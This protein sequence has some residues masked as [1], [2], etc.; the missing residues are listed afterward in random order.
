MVGRI[1]GTTSCRSR[2]LGEDFLANDSK[3]SI[4]NRS[5]DGTIYVGDH[6]T[7]SPISCGSRRFRERI[8]KCFPL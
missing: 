8:F 6:K 5:K 7:C 2:G 1:Y 4:D 3:T